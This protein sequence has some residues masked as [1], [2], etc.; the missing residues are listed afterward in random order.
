MSLSEEVVV[1]TGAGRGI[2]RAIAVAFGAEGAHVVCISRTQSELESVVAE[3]EEAKPAARPALSSTKH[4]PA[5]I[6]IVHDLSDPA[7][8]PAL[9]DKIHRCLGKT[10]VDILVNNAGIARFEALQSGVDL[11]IYQCVLNTNL[12]SPISLTL[13]LLPEMLRNERGIIISIGSR[14]AGMDIPFSSAY[15]VSKTGLLKFHQT[16]EQEVGGKGIL[17]YYLQ[18]G[19]IATGIMD[20]K[21]AQCD[22][23]K[24]VYGFGM[25]MS[26]L[27][28]L[29]KDKPERV[30]EACVLLVT[31]R[32]AARMSGLYV[33]LDEDVGALIEDLGKEKDKSVVKTRGLNKLKVE[34]L[35][36]VLW[37]MQCRNP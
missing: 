32:D 21:T 12:S 18:P 6:A 9:V 24:Y 26:R 4:L 14:S 36:R 7:T 13:S 17:N 27:R 25:A 23:S 15:S 31:E 19:N 22:E 30:A 16:L 20:P 29:P 33:D 34:T 2:G 35:G 8:I 10:P 5:A 11:R 37:E 3:I 28:W 1:V